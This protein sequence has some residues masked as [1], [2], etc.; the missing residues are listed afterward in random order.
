VK[1]LAGEKEA[2]FP[3][4][5]AKARFVRKNNAQID[6]DLPKLVSWLEERY[7]VLGIKTQRQDFMWRGQVHSNLI[8]IIPGRL[9]KE[10][11]KP[12]LMADHIDTAFCE[13]IFEKTGE[14]VAAKGANDNMTAAAALLRAAE[15]L[16]KMRPDH[17]IWLTHLTGEEFPG[18]DLGARHLVSDFLARKIEIRGLILMDMIGRHLPGGDIFQVNA[19]DS[20]QSLN[21]ARLI[22]D[23]APSVTE[24]RP[25]LRKRFDRRS[26]LYNTDGLIFSDVGY[27]VV[28]LNEHINLLENFEFPGYHD[29]VDTSAQIDF[30]YAIGIVKVAI[31]SA[32]RL[33]K[34]F[35]F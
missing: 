35:S 5:G 34:D 6:N 1:I 29:V 33:S 9:P 21:I 32:A 31:E 11:N 16:K 24:S 2:I 10:K 8:A 18:D 28:F 15:I 23:A 12:V 30:D 26:Y 3:L 14:R 20:Q 4:S 19:G 13:D 27:P 17:D 7:A 22:M 25:V